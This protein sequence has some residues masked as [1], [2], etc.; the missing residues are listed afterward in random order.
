M[1][2]ASRPRRGS[3]Q[4]WP[5]KRAKKI[6]PSVN[7]RGISENNSGKKLQGFIGYKV[8]MKSAFVKDITLDSMTKNKR[9]SIPVTIIE[10][11]PMKI[12][13]ARFYKN[14]QVISEVLA[15]NLDKEL[16]RKVKMPKKNEK[17]LE[18]VKDYED[19]RI[20]TYSTVKKTGIKKKPDMVEIALGGELQSKL[21]F[22]KEKFDKEISVKE[23]FDNMQLI[24][25]RGLTKGKGNQGAVKRYGIGL[26]GHKSE[27]GRRN[28]GSLGPWHPARVT[29]RVP[30]AG[31]LGM[32]TRV[33]YNHKIVN[34]GQINENNVN[35]KEGFKKFGLMKTDYV[36]VNGSLQGPSKR[37][38]ILTQPLRATKKQQKK[39]YEF[40]ELR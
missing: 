21:N 24:D 12:F 39:N 33:D 7:W 36:I 27:K 5:R 30:H 3:L 32:F 6:L 37:Q 13:S 38:L 25:I 10:C 22:V 35:P 40:I 9:V 15:K 8:G 16:K 23:I 2:Q 20:I 19:I 31:Q 28:P 11:P 17:K 18:D 1:G 4:Y 26:K 29:F 14:G 34:L